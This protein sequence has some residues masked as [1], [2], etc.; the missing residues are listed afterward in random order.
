MLERSWIAPAPVPRGRPRTIDL[1]AIVAAG[2]ALADAEGV[3]G[4]SMPRVAREVG[5]T[6]NALYRHV[7]SKDDLLALIADAGS[8]P[9]PTLD[10]GAGWRPAARAWADALL[11]RYG[12]RPWL[13]DVRLRT[14]FTRNIVLWTECFLRAT[15]SSGLATEVRL[16]FAMLLDAQARHRAALHRDLAAAPPD[17]GVLI[18]LLEANDCAEYAAYLRAPGQESPGFGVERILDSMASYAP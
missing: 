2:V 9:P 4:V 5:V 1:P 10:A 14:P 6:Q 12:S 17:L 3:A 7:A 18:P 11:A 13:L 15:R 8:G 16:E